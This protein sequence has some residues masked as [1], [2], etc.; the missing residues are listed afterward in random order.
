[1][2]TIKYDI[3]VYI[4]MKKVQEASIIYIRVRQTCMC[5]QPPNRH[6]VDYRFNIR[7]Y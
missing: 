4:I 6:T 7:Y 3:Y 5:V 2:L 1:M